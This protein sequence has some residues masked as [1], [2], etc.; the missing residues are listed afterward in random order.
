MILVTGASGL[1][2][3]NLVRALLAGGQA[4]RVLVRDDRRAVAGLGV[5]M[6]TGD[7]RDPA[8]LAR[9]VRGVELVYHLA[10]IITVTEDDW[11]RLEA[12][13]V[14]GTRNVV[15]ACLGAGGAAQDRPRMVHFSSI[16]G[17]RSEPSA[18]PIDETRALADG[19]EFA[20]YDRSKA[21]SEREVT[22]GMARGLDAII[23]NPTAVLGPFDFKPSYIGSGIRMLMRGWIPALVQ[24]GYNWVDVRD[25]AAGAIRA[26]STAPTG[27]KYILGGH[28]RSLHE[29]AA[30]V[31]AACGRPAPRLTI[32][33]GV[34]RAFAP[35]MAGAARLTGSAPIYTPLTLDVLQSHRLVSSAKAERELGYH[36]RPFEESVADT[37]RWIREQ[38]ARHG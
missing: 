33:L 23:L 4:V 19:A 11:P 36:S 16:H 8:G 37:V 21:L 6:V 29:M 20:P 14:T 27:S 5:E 31:A 35:L 17:L 18:E 25:V 15:E 38:E 22:A 7:V 34:A 26:A 9:A 30:A 2:G 1:I 12:V 3:A 24:G 10:G 32:P 13:N 28:W